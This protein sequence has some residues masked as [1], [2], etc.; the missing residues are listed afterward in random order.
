MKNILFLLKI[1]DSD[2]KLNYRK[3]HIFLRFGIFLCWG[4]LVASFITGAFESRLE[5]R[6]S[7][8][9]ITQN[10]KLYLL[11]LQDDL[12]N[13]KSFYLSM[14]S[15]HKR[16]GDYKYSI[17][18]RIYYIEELIK[19]NL[20]CIK[21][22]NTFYLSDK[23]QT[24][25]ENLKRKISNFQKDKEIFLETKLENYLKNNLPDNEKLSDN[26]IINAS[27]SIFDLLNEKLNEINDDITFYDEEI[28]FY[29]DLSSMTFIITF[30]VQLFIF[31]L[32]QSF[33]VSVERRRIKSEK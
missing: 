12:E 21:Y 17:E 8:G 32:I 5:N 27:I 20:R 1:I 9:N 26:E 29:N 10:Y 19:A 23:E 30:F 13:K 16:F 31:I 3:I 4:C 15:F 24:Q 25:I 28:K 2:L 33:E 6:I 22:L 7:N 14:D 11:K 18:N